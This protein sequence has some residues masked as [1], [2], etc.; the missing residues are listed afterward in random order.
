M[1]LEKASDFALGDTKSTYCCYCTDKKG[2]LLPFETVLA[3]NAKFYVESQGITEAAAEKM[4]RTMM[5]EMPA[6]KAHAR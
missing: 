5:A 3:S 2:Q 6:W 1:P 4:A